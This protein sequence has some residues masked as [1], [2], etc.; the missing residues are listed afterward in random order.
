MKKGYT[1]KNRETGATTNCFASLWSTATD[2][3]GCSPF[4]GTKPVSFYNDVETYG[5]YDNKGRGMQC[6]AFTNAVVYAMGY[7]GKNLYTG[8]NQD[9]FPSTSASIQYFDDPA[10][11]M[12]PTPSEAR[13]SRPGSVIFIRTITGYD[14]NNNPI[15]SYANYYTVI[16]VNSGNSDTV[17][18]TSVQAK[19]NLGS[20]VTIEGNDLL[21][22]KISKYARGYQFAQPGD[23]VFK[24]ARVPNAGATDHFVIVVKTTGNYGSVTAVDVVD[25]NYVGDEVIGYHTM[26]TAELAKY[27]VYA[28]VSYYDEIL[29]PNVPVVPPVPSPG[30]ETVLYRYKNTEY[31]GDPEDGKVYEIRKDTAGKKYKHWIIDEKAFTD[32]G[33]NWSKVI[34][35]KFGYNLRLY[36]DGENIGFKEGTLIKRPD[37]K[38][39]EIR[40]N[41][42]HWFPNW[43]SFSGK[44]YTLAMTYSVSDQLADRIPDGIAVDYRLVKTAASGD[45]YVIQG[46][47]KKHIM[48]PDAMAIWNLIGIK[49]KPLAARK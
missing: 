48:D 5:F 44:G 24:S 11:I 20:I 46:T 6:K 35:D 22:Y 17:T 27:Y 4:T 30:P 23:V 9:I 18:V 40:N 19:N 37:G 10:K 28:G 26:Q 13:Y 1:I 39:Y 16:S 43:N 47:E 36:I 15:Y 25:S 8:K 21:Q 49:S 38:I 33:Y 34:D 2:G 12:N 42:K 41:E 7:A 45:I 29:S 3:S 14:K 31:Y 32:R